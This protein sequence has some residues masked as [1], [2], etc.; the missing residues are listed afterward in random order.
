MIGPGAI[1]VSLTAANLMQCFDLLI[2]NNG[3]YYS[4]RSSSYI[5]GLMISFC[6]QCFLLY[7][8]KNSF[9]NEVLLNT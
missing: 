4:H 1:A 3:G 7:C 9:L 8:G 6:V 2:K 5:S